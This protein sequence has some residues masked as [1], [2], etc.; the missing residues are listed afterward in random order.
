VGNG[1]WGAEDFFN[2]LL[3]AKV[4]ASQQN[5]SALDEQ[6]FPNQG[7]GGRKTQALFIHFLL[8]KTFHLI[9]LL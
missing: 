7:R 8:L 1:K 9:Y 3:P 4:M 2:F 5:S 6:R